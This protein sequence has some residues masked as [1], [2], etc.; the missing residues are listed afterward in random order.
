[1]N[2][3]QLINDQLTNFIIDLSWQAP[4]RIKGSLSRET[5][6]ESSPFH[7]VHDSVFC[8]NLN[9]ATGLSYFKSTW[10]RATRVAEN[11]YLSS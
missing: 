3:F 1:M 8:C 7:P 11:Y 10:V 4:R 9:L 5:K 6:P 2:I